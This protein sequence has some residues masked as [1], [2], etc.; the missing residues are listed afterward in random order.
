MIIELV[1]DNVEYCVLYTYWVD[2]LLKVSIWIQVFLRVYGEVGS[3]ITLE[4]V[5][6]CSFVI[7]VM[8]SASTAYFK[9]VDNES[10]YY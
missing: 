2:N 9:D 6:Q 8:Q 10:T 3:I 5:F 7:F 4:I 1:N